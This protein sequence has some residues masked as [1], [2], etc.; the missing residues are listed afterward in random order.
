MPEEKADGES[1]EKIEQ[2]KVEGKKPEAKAERK[3]P[4]TQAEAREP[5]ETNKVEINIEPR[6]KDVLLLELLQHCVVATPHSGK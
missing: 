5:K 4:G 2:S 1:R 6:E 3:K